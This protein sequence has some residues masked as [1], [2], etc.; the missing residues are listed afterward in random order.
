M[1]WINSS[2]DTI[3]L[4]A[5]LGSGR[6]LTTV[7]PA[8]VVDLPDYI[9]QIIISMEAPQLV[10]FVSTMVSKPEVTEE[11]IDALP[12]EVQSLVSDPATFKNKRG[13]KSNKVK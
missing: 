5:D 2:G 10:P 12:V 6:M 9:D 7:L 1:K 4:N 3:R 8:Q 11:L 13:R